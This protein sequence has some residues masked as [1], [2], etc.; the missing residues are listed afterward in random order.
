[1]E[2]TEGKQASSIIAKVILIYWLTFFKYA[3]FRNQKPIV[4][5]FGETWRRKLKNEKCC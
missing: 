2:I 4:A 1:M 5:E 3:R